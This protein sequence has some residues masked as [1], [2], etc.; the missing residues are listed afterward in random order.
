MKSVEV[1][2]KI[3]APRDMV[4]DEISE[5]IHPPILHKDIIKSVDPI[6]DD[7]K[8]SVAIWRLKVLGFVSEAIQKQVINRPGMMTNETVGGFA[9]GTLE[10]TYLYETGEGTEIVDNIDIRIPKLGKILDMPV[11]WY[12]KRITQRILMDHKLDLE[13]RYAAVPEQGKETMLV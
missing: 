6:V 11:A 9:K 13:S 4:L 5:Y 1:R 10:S 12:T 3:K 2:I 7:G 8:V